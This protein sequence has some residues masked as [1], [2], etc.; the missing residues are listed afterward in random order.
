M[1]VLPG[2]CC[3]LELPRAWLSLSFLCASTYRVVPAHI[4]L[5]RQH[6]HGRAAPGALTGTGPEMRLTGVGTIL[7]ECAPAGTVGLGLRSGPL[8]L[9]PPHPTPCHHS[10]GLTGS[11]EYTSHS[12]HRLRP[13]SPHRWNVPHMPQPSLGPSAGRGGQLSKVATLSCEARVAKAGGFMLGR[14]GLL[15]AWSPRHERAGAEAGK[16]VA[17]SEGSALQMLSP[18]PLAIVGL[19]WWDVIR[20]RKPGSMGSNC[21]TLCTGSP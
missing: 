9:A 2:P 14:Q 8:P 12:R 4:D 20:Y 7:L 5:R 6:C 11:P 3:E 17:P 1:E 19:T 15:E 13:H 16:E 10:Q 21:M 18:K